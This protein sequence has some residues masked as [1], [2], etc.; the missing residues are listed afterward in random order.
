MP[1]TLQTMAGFFT[2]A[3][4]GTNVATPAPG[5]NFS[6]ASFSPSSKA[7]LENVSAAGAT[8]DF[9]RIRSP[10]LH[11]VNQGLRLFTGATKQR[12]LLPWGM[13]ETLYSSDNPTVEIDATG[14]GSGGI[15]VTYGYDDL[16][17]G[18]PRLDVWPSI[19]PRIVHVSGVEVDV[20]SGAIGAWGNGAAINSSFD[21]FEAGA[22]YALL[23]YICSEP[24]L[25]VALTGKDTSNF[26]IGGPGDGDPIKTREYFINAANETGRPFIPIIAANNKG[27]TILQN[28]DVAAATAIKVTLLLAQLA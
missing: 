24:C 2:A 19:Q 1:R 3:G 9:V 17:G 16:N 13:N 11:D 25:G 10:R 21:N 15:L 23:G 4:A 27:G 28:V 22:D 18:N 20:T 26:K 8:T 7:Y 6:V 12:N 14:A 5:D